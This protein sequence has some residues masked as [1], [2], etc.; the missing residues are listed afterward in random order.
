MLMLH[1]SNITCTNLN[2]S[3]IPETKC[4]LRF[5]SYTIR[6]PK[7]LVRRQ[8]LYPINFIAKV[9]DEPNG[10]D[11]FKLNYAVHTNLF[12]QSQAEYHL[13][14]LVPTWWKWKVFFP[15]SSKYFVEPTVRRDIQQ[16]GFA[17]LR[18]LYLPI[19]LNYLK[20]FNE[21]NRTELKGF[22]FIFSL[23]YPIY[24]CFLLHKY[25]CK[26]LFLAWK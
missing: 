14:K 22:N 4:R 25:I 2:F 13:H 10:T 5:T 1:R 20:I 17:R 8:R 11:I 6:A 7:P 24:L 18:G 19:R 26:W 21:L 16:A 15:V 3:A 9:I 23:H 12:I